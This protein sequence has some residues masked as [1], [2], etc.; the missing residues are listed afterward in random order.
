MTL[1]AYTDENG[2]SEC[3]WGEMVLNAYESDDF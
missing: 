1:N 2:G 3:L